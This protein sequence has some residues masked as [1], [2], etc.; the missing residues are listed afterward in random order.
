ME[1][2]KKGKLITKT[3][4]TGLRIRTKIALRHNLSE[5]QIQ[6]W[7]RD[8]DPRL[9]EPENVKIITEESQLSEKE[10]FKLPKK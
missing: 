5:R 9:G 4:P 6:N 10:L 3:G 7:V 2:T 8:N 1:L